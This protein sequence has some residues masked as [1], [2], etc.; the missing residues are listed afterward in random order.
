LPSSGKTTALGKKVPER[1]IVIDSDSY[2]QKLAQR[3]RSP[4]KKYPLAHA[5]YLHDESDILVKQAVERAIAEKRDVTYDATMK[6]YDKGKALI[7]RFKKAGYDVHYLATQKSPAKTI[8]HAAKRFIAKGRYVP[9]EYIGEYGNQISKNSWKAR[10]LGDTYE[11]YNTNTK[12]NKLIAKSRKDMSYNF[13][14]PA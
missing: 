8:I 7:E 10:K 12:K 2:K 9:L 5:S 4:I 1:T 6:S 11:V 3:S 14:G 13:R